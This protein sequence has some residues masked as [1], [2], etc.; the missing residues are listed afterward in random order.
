MQQCVEFCTD[1]VKKT[2]KKKLGVL[3]PRT[4]L[5]NPLEQYLEGI[6]PENAHEL[7]TNK[8]FISVTVKKKN[9]LVSEFQDRSDLL[10]VCLKKI[11]Y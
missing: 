5:L 7:A 1:L 9:K 3:T 8:L 6:L 2:R 10:K 11:N 4:S